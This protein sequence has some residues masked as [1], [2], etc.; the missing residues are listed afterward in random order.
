MFNPLGF[1]HRLRRDR[2]QAPCVAQRRYRPCI[3]DLEDR[4][5]LTGGTAPVIAMQPVLSGLNNPLLVTNAADGSNRLFVVE[6]RGVIRVLQ[7]GSTSSTV[8]LNLSDV[9]VDGVPGLN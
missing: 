9:I 8:F 6:Q 5:L 7:P 3:E 4:S 2:R 1:P